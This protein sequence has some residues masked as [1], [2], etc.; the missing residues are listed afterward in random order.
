MDRGST[1]KW[2]APLV[3][4]GLNPIALYCLWQLTGGFFRE[5]LRIHLGSHVFETFGLA[6]TPMLERGS[7]LLIFW[8]ILFW[9]HRRKIYIRL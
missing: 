6:W 5:T 7:V 3:V 9:M 1:P 4:A 2:A 8:L